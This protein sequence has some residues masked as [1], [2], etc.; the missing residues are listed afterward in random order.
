MELVWVDMYNGIGFCV[1][2]CLVTLVLFFNFKQFASRNNCEEYYKYI[3]LTF[4]SIILLFVYI[5]VF[6]CKEITLHSF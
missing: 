2:F 5:T 1:C 6:Q 3:Y 4:T